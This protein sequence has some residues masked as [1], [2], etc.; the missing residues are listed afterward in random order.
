[1]ETKDFVRIWNPGDFKYSPGLGGNENDARVYFWN[2]SQEYLLKDIREEINNG[3]KPITEIGPSSFKL[4]TSTS[5]HFT[6]LMTGVPARV[7]YE[8]VEFRIVLMKEN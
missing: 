4:R 5:G 2:N 1:M 6:Q 3:W 7:W 8:V